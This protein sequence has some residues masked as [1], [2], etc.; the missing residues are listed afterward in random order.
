MHNTA[1]PFPSSPPSRYERVNQLLFLLA[2][3]CVPFSTWL[4]N[5]F[6]GLSLLLFAAALPFNAALRRAV[7]APAA[8]LALGLL[9]LFAVG[10]AWSIGPREEVADALRKYARLL[11]LP[12][13]IALNWRDPLLARRALR[14]MLG[15]LAVLA[16]SSYLVWLE[17]MPTSS[18]GWWRIGDV[19]DAYAFKNHITIGILLGFAS[20]ACLLRASWCAAW[21]A[22][23]GWAALMLLFMIPVIF[24]NQGRTGYVA[25]FIGL[26]TVFVLRVRFTP[27]R[28]AAALAGTMLLFAGFYATSDNFKFRTDL[29]V[30]ELSSD[31][32][33]TANGLRM[34]YLRVGLDAVLEHP[35]IGLGTGSFA[36]A[37]AP[38][39]AR[40]WNDATRHQP[41]SEF[42]LVAVQ[43]GLT[44]LLCYFVMLGTLL[45]PGLKTRTYASDS[46]VL[47]WTI[48]VSASSFNSLLWD[49][50]EAC[51]FLL[52]SSCLYVASVRAGDTATL[53]L[54]RPNT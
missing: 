40:I 50:T 16:A 24:L 20:M 32:E 52:L 47:L 33:N 43:L 46:L 38:T 18:L 36:T 5:V 9:A 37:Y 44:G 54:N 13:G 25:V 11:I 6:L 41:H 21:P 2:V 49:T 51:W 10:S 39:A 22:R 4:T 27:L 34:S 53:P 19:R 26:L 30:K 31:A 15:G 1:G 14:C 29:M 45:R 28:L 3:F 48:Y 12:M 8:L 35:V 23:A 17:M 42:L 7:R